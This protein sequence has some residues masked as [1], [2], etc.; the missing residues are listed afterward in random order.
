MNS[1][2]YVQG[3]N[4]DRKAGKWGMNTIFFAASLITLLYFIYSCIANA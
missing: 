2:P 1:V 4:I 3:E